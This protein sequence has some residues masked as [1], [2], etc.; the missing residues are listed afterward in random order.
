MRC[1]QCNSRKHNFLAS[2]WTS[3]YKTGMADYNLLGIYR[4][5]NNANRL[6]LYRNK[7]GNNY[8]LR[9][10]DPLTG[11]TKTKAVPVKHSETETQ[12]RVWSEHWLA[13]FKTE[14]HQPENDE[15]HVPIHTM[16]MMISRWFEFAVER[17]D[18]VMMKRFRSVWKKL[19]HRGIA[20]MELKNIS[21]K[22]IVEFVD[23]L[24][25][26]PTKT[27]RP[28]S[29][30]A[31]RDVMWSLRKMLNEM[32]FLS[33][34]PLQANLFDNP[35]VKQSIP[36]GRKLSGDDNIYLEQHQIK[37][38]LA[39]NGKQHFVHL[40]AVA[41]GMR[42]AEIAGLAWK[43]IDM[44]NRLINIERQ[45]VSKDV[46]KDPKKNSKRIIP[47]HPTLYKE[48]VARRRVG[49]VPVVPHPIH[50]GYWRRDSAQMLRDD[51]AQA[52]LPV[53]F[54]NQYPFTFHALRRTFATLLDFA[55]VD[56]AD[57]S[58]LLGHKPAGTTARHYIGKHLTRIRQAVEKLDL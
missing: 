46:F 9:Y 6:A 25:T 11:A 42:D 4:T 39:S 20:K 40:L 58:A 30:Y 52:G 41:T 56:K 13:A 49:D 10:N 5:I 45:F 26:T 16:E 8:I 17:N 48:L 51:M 55:N 3:F 57:I 28:L 37:Q 34:V 54:D 1:G 21:V 29:P 43:H 15:I 18:P 47:I 33:N 23:W 31:L 19:E 35:I 22:H 53:M 24:K 32:S 50:G 44:E 38:L 27:G 14:A 36:T 7:R 2:F 12:A